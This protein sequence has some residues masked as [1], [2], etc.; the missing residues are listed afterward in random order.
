[1]AIHSY[2]SE[3]AV[4]R[5]NRFA[6]GIAHPVKYARQS[7]SHHFIRSKLIQRPPIPHVSVRKLVNI[8]VAHDTFR[9]IDKFV[10]ANFPKITHANH[11]SLTLSFTKA[12][13]KPERIMATPPNTI[14]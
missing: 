5:V 7:D 12:I 4:G 13:R 10:R 1:M 9:F 8:T 6:P 3:T 11:A 2:L 14:A